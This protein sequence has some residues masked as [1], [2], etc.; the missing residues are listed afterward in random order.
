MLTADLLS[1]AF[2]SSQNSSFLQNKKKILHQ[3]MFLKT[4]NLAQHCQKNHKNN[5][6]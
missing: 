1:Q 3:F 2:L 4:D 6:Y 5:H